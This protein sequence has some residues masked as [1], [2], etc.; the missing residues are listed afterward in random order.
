MIVRDTFV[1][2][3]KGKAQGAVRIPTSKSIAHRALICAALCAKPSRS[4]ISNVPYNEDID[5]TLDCLESLGVYFRCE[6][7]FEKNTR[8]VIVQGRG[9]QWQDGDRGGAILRC[10]ESGS[11][12]RFMLPLCLLTGSGRTLTGSPRLLQRPLDDYRP[13]FEGRSWTL[14]EVSLDIGWGTVLT[15]GDFI[16][17]G[18]PA[19]SSLQGCCSFCLF[20]P[21]T[22][23]SH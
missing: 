8:T 13:L 17:K 20:S 23:P 16:L 18:R 2:V 15:G 5:A 4:I 7:D 1:T 12:L 11:T 9:G 6:N 10:R 3:Q 21:I 22:V 14:G 19:A